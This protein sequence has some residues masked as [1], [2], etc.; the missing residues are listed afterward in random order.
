MSAKQS[1]NNCDVS[2][3]QSKISHIIPA[4]LFGV[5]KLACEARLKKQTVNIIFFVKI[6]LLIFPFI[7]FSFFMS[8]QFCVL[9]L[10]FLLSLFVSLHL[11]LIQFFERQ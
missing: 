9:H 6:M 3:D 5:A 1:L 10:S 2:S 4:I 7:Q 11:L 8:S